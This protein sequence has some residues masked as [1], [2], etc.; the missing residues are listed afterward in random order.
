MYDAGKEDYVR[1]TEH[2]GLDWMMS[3]QQCS[4]LASRGPS[5]ARRS[6]VDIAVIN[7]LLS[8]IAV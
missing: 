1:P 4:S 6:R 7:K 8:I 5:V 2:I 3:S